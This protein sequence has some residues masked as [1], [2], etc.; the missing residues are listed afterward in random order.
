MDTK[1]S[2][3][4]FEEK[5]KLSL[6]SITSPKLFLN[7]KGKNSDSTVGNHGRHHIAKYS[8]LM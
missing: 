5:Q 4:K 7:D 6:V 3:Q 8:K 2:E 1:I